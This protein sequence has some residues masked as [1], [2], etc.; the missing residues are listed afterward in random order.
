M[1][2]FEKFI[3][4]GQKCFSKKDMNGA[5]DNANKALSVCE[6]DAEFAVAYLMRGSIYAQ[7]DNPTQAIEDWKK[8]ADYGNEDALQTLKNLG[9]RY[10]PKKPTAMPTQTAQRPAAQSAPQPQA[11]I[12][13]APVN[14]VWEFSPQRY[15]TVEEIYKKQ[16]QRVK[17]GDKLLKYNGK[18]L[19][20]EVEGTITYI[21]PFTLSTEGVFVKIAIGK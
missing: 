21:V 16:G 4:M 13:A 10:T 9:I 15:S 1:D 3:T 14:N 19:K 20:S 5:M 17:K 11:P 7:I 18:V 12:P 6:L 2:A 8:S